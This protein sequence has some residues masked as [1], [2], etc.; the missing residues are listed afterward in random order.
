MTTL[1]WNPITKGWEESPATGFMLQLHLRISNMKLGHITVPLSEKIKA[2]FQHAE[3]HTLRAVNFTKEGGE[4]FHRHT[5]QIEKMTISSCDF[6]TVAVGYALFTDRYKCS[7]GCT[8]HIQA[9]A[10]Y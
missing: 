3:Q 9:Y 10:R 6:D 7:C 1:Y 8:A 4:I 5:F 2:L